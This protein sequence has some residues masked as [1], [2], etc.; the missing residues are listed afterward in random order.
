MRV[1]LA[2]NKEWFWRSDVRRRFQ[3]KVVGELKWEALY[4]QSIADLTARSY[5]CIYHCNHH[6]SCLDRHSLR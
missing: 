2:Y 4:L 3:A 6:H 5:G 1:L